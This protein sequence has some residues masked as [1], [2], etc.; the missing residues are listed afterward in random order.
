MAVLPLRL[1]GSPILRRKTKKIEKIT[2]G[3]RRLV[4]DMEETLLFKKGLGLAAP[5][6]GKSL[7]LAIVNMEGLEKGEGT[8]VLVNPELIYFEGS[9]VMEEGCLSI[10]GLYYNLERPKIIVV[11][12]QVLE[13]DEL[14][15][16]EIEAEGLFARVLLHE[17]DHL[18]GILFVDRIEP[19]VSSLLVAKWRREI[20]KERREA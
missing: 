18:Q 10:P 19:R 8:L 7:S 9:E 5:Q 16:K 17:I 1:L 3:I 13:E 2:P 12:T 11:K 4:R 14:R 15:E 20:Q 6:V